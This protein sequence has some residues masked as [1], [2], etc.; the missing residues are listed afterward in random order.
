[1]L[2]ITSIGALMMR[3]WARIGMIAWAGLYIAY[4]VISGIA[5]IIITLPSRLEALKGKPEYEVARMTAI[6][7]AS[8]ILLVLL[9]LPIVTLVVM[10]KP[11]VVAA[12]EGR[13]QAPGY[14]PSSA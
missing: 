11:E 8:M 12:F 1:M 10:R 4:D 3:P 2:L 5:S 6:I 13:Q 14:M 9:V 7:V